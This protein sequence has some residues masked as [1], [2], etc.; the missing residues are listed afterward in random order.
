[1]E[2]T[3]ERYQTRFDRELTEAEARQWDAVH[4]AVLSTVEGYVKARLGWPLAEPPAA[5]T[6]AALDLL[7]FRLITKPGQGTTQ[8]K[9]AADRALLYLDRIAAGRICFDRSVVADSSCGA[10]ACG[11]DLFPELDGML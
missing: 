2:L 6:D 9:E 11:A 3:R 5:V 7:R 8:I 10:V 4:P 1:M